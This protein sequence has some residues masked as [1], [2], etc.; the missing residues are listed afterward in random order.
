M[1][2]LIE[3]TGL[4]FAPGQKL[5]SEALNII[6]DRLGELIKITNG[7]LLSVA[8]INLETGNLGKTYTIEEA[9]SLVPESRR[10]NGITVKFI[11]P[12][13]TWQMHTYQ[14]R[15]KQGWLN[16]DNWTVDKNNKI[17]DGGQW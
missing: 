12:K 9:I 5:S 4:S 1:R 17:I 3:Q 16:L 15:D 7:F 2:E 13:K 8:N 10:V 6:N 11:G 14:G